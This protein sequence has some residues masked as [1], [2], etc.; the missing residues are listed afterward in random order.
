MS[1]GNINEGEEDKKGENEKEC[2]KKETR[3]LENSINGEN[4]K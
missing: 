4:D 3:N 2:K 1:K